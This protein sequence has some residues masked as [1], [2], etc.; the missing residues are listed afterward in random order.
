ME[1]LSRAAL[2]GPAYLQHLAA[3]VDA[4]KQ[5]CLQFSRRPSLQYLPA[6]RDTAPTV[7]DTRS[8]TTAGS[9]CAESRHPT[10][11]FR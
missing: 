8:R 1:Y 4:D 7:R 9:V 6:S 11:F 3:H 2:Q 5:A 10:K